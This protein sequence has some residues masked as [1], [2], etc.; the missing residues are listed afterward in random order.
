MNKGNI[1]AL[2]VLVFAVG[3]ILGSFSGMYTASGRITQSVSG[4]AVS[5]RGST[6]TV[7]IL[8]DIARQNDIMQGY[9]QP[10]SNGALQGI[11]FYSINELGQLDSLADECITCFCANNQVCYDGQDYSFVLPEFEPGYYAASVA[12]AV[13]NE[14]VYAVFMVR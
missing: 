9:V 2:I 13:T 6:L 10:G 4:Q 7:S 11:K 8:P 12:D 3:L 1:T 14:K 5:Q